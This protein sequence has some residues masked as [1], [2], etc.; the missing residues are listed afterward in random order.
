MM[1]GK[2]DQSTYLVW[3]HRRYRYDPGNDP[4]LIGEQNIVGFAGIRRAGAVIFDIELSAFL[5]I[6]RQ[7]M[8][9]AHV[10]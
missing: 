6:V 9:R 7:R 1:R 4:S 5:E 2:E 10:E 3:A 8:D